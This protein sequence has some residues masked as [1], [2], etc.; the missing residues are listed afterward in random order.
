MRPVEEFGRMRR[1]LQGGTEVLLC[2]ESPEVYSKKK[3][4]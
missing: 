1:S 3:K 2:L 4:A